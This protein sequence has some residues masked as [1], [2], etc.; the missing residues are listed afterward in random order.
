MYG[1]SAS[2]LPERLH[3]GKMPG[4]AVPDA[5]VD[6]W[7]QEVNALPMRKRGKWKSWLEDK[8]GQRT[9]VR[10]VPDTGHFENFYPSHVVHQCSWVRIF[11][12]SEVR[13]RDM[14][15]TSR[16]G[17]AM[18]ANDDGRRM[19]LLAERDANHTGNHYRNHH[20]KV[21]TAP[22]EPVRG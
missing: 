20:I 14:R 1:A 10:Y 4:V 2:C 11:S 21:P 19:A 5:L 7:R 16:L 8:H 13:A 12:T 17:E 18:Y 15:P 6:E 3:Y 9:R 22:G